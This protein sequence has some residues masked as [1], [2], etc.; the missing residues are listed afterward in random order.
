ML[1][2]RFERDV[3]PH[4]G[5]KPIAELKAVELLAVLRKIEVRG[6]IET[7]HRARSDC[8]QVFR[9]AIAT[10]R[11]ERD[12]AAD[13]IG[14]LEP[15]VTKHFPSVT[16]PVKVAGLLRAVDGYQGSFFVMAAM[17]LA[18]LLFVGPG[19]LRHAE[20]K[21]INLDTAEW[22]YTV[23][24]KNENRPYRPA[25]RSSCGHPAGIA[26]C[27]WG[28]PVCLPRRSQQRQADER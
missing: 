8:G 19:E 20:W 17:R 28:R 16:E 18:P 1:L 26:R 21:D 25:C 27:D 3:F 15:K 10:G 23:S 6:A 14:A 4:I 5:S 2:R 22:R 11:A 13:L 7:T 24:N 12:I 9:Y